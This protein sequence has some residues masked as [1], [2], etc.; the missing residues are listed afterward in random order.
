MTREPQSIQGRGVSRLG[1]GPP[2]PDTTAWMPECPQGWDHPPGSP[3]PPCQG[4]RLTCLWLKPQPLKILVL[5][6][7]GE[8]ASRL[9]VV[10]LPLLQESFSE[11]ERVNTWT[12]LLGAGAELAGAQGCTAGPYGLCCFGA[13]S[14]APSKQPSSSAL[15]MGVTSGPRVHQEQ[16]RDPPRRPLLLPQAACSLTRLP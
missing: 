3:E 10:L 2:P 6:A 12:T 7:Q 11:T 5:E 16:D 1:W 9:N 15:L 14:S 13:A 8:L 4:P